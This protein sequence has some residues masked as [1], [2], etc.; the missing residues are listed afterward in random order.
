MDTL[1]P[2]L[3]SH[4]WLQPN[5]SRLSCGG[6][7]RRRKVK[8]RQAVP[9][10]GHNTPVPLK[11][12]PPASFKRLLGGNLSALVAPGEA[13]RQD[14]EQHEQRDTTTSGGREQDRYALRSHP[15][16]VVDAQTNVACCQHLHAGALGHPNLASLQ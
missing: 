10:Q 14:Q 7:A 5:G 16:P 4:L 9:R 11:R 2:L 8:G 15:I 12:S 6:L 1:G 13:R 3:W